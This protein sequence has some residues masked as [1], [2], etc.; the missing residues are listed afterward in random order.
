M[1]IR[2]SS[3][4]LLK[5]MLDIYNDEKPWLIYS[6]WGGYTKEGKDYTNSDVINIRNLFGDRILDGTM[7]G[8]HTSG[9]ADVET[10]KEVCQTVHP[11]IGVIPIHK[12]EN[13]R[14]DSISGISSYFIFD[15]GDVDIHDI[16]ISIK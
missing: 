1:P 8:V 11:R 10:L 4:Y 3:G 7:D 12:D 2:M 14:Y 15:E 13:S 6:M 5:G 16:H 9:H